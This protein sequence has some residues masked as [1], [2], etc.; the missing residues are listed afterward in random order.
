MTAQATPPHIAVVL[1]AHGDPQLTRDVAFWVEACRQQLLQHAA[2]AWAEWAPP[3]GVFFYGTA[4]GM[5]PDDVATI[6]IFRSAGD[7]SANG[8]HAAIGKRVLG[9]VDLGRSSIPSRTLSHEVLEMYRNPY[10]AEWAA[11]PRTNQ[12]YAV[13]LCDPVQQLSYEIEVELMGERRRVQVADFLTP[14]WFNGNRPT[15]DHLHQ[16]PPFGI[17]S[18]GYQ[19][20]REDD[21]ILWLPAEGEPMRASAAL[22]PLSRTSMISRGIT[23]CPF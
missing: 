19:I 6:G 12:L 13:E 15:G 5:P 16:V 7:D 1:H 22:R 18:G 14:A 21:R 10:L 17:A 8:Y 20:A 23:V 4:E 9:A 2:P 11:S 3:P